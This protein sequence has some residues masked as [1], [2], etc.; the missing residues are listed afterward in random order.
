MASEKYPGEDL[1]LQGQFKIKEAADLQITTLDEESA[2][3]EA[4]SKSVLSHLRKITAKLKALDAGNLYQGNINCSG[5]PNY[6]AASKDQYWRV[7]VAGKIGG[8]SGVFVEVGDMIYCLADNAG[9]TEAAVGANF[10]VQQANINRSYVIIAEDAYTTDPETNVE[11][12]ASA[13]DLANEIKARLNE[14]FADAGDGALDSAILLANSLKMTMNLHLN[15]QGSGTEE[16][17]AKND[18]IDADDATDLT[19]LI[20]LTTEMLTVYDSAGLTTI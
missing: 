2:Y 16:H 13:I 20:A 17:K 9:G 1:N 18:Q 4:E 12:I 8:A 3:L 19:T 5:N 10:Q 11:G 15:D 6:P 7:S 14:H